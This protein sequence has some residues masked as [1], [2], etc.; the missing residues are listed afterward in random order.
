MKKILII[1][2]FECQK[3]VD[4]AKYI[5]SEFSSFFNVLISG[6]N[7]KK[8]DNLP[9][10]KKSD[11]IYVNYIISADIIFILDADTNFHKYKRNQRVIYF[12]TNTN[13]ALN[14]GR[15]TFEN[16]YKKIQ[17]I[18]DHLVFA[19]DNNTTYEEIDINFYQYLVHFKDSDITKV[20]DN[21]NISL[22][23]DKL[24]NELLVITNEPYLS[25]Y[26]K[27]NLQ[28]FI[29]KLVREYDCYNIILL[30]LDTST[31]ESLATLNNTYSTVI[32][33]NNKN[34][35][36]YLNTFDGV[37]IYDNENTLNEYQEILK[38]HNIQ[39]RSCKKINEELLKLYFNANDLNEFIDDLN[40]EDSLYTYN[41]VKALENN[42]TDE[43]KNKK[44]SVIIARYNTPLDLL[45]RAINSVFVSD[46][47]N[48]EVVLV[49]D[50]SK[51]NIEDKIYHDYVGK[52]IKYI[53][54]HNQGVGPAR[55]TGIKASSGDYVFFLDSDD[56]IIKTGLKLML[57]HSEIF[58]LDLVIG[59]RFICDENGDYI[60]H[61]FKNLAS[62]TY[63]VY[64]K[65][66]TNNVYEDNMPTNKLYKK[67]IF[68]ENNLLFESG[69]F[70]D[71]IFTAL[72][73]NYVDEYHYLNIPIYTW[74][75]YGEEST[76]SS[77][78]TFDNF[79]QRIKAYQKTWDIINDNNR[80]SLLLNNIKAFKLYLP[81]LPT[82]SKEEQ[83]MFFEKFQKYVMERISYYS[84][85]RVPFLINI[86][87]KYLMNNDFAGFLKFS[88]EYNKAYSYS[89]IVMDNYICY[90]H[91]HIYTAIIRTIDSKRPSRLY[92][93]KDYQKINDKFLNKIND[94]NIFEDVISFS[95]GNIVGE[96]K[97]ALINHPD[98]E[99]MIIEATLYQKFNYLFNNCN[100][101]DSVYVFN[102]SLP[103]YLTLEKK[104]NNIFRVEDAYNSFKRETEI[105]ND[106]G[107]W[108][109]ILSKYRGNMFPNTHG[110]SDK[111]KNI[112]VSEPIDNIDEK[113]TNKLLV[114]NINDISQKHEDELRKIFTYI[115]DTNEDFNENTILILTQP[116]GDNYCTIN[117]QIRLYQ[118]IAS[119]YRK[120]D[121]IIKPHP[122]DYVNY[123]KYGYKTL[124]RNVPIEVYNLSG[125]KIKKA[126][127]FGSSSI[128]L[129][130]FAQEKEILFKMDDFVTDDVNVAIKEL[131]GKE[132]FLD[133]NRVKNKLKR[134][135]KGK[136]NK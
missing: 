50:G 41:Y 101:N 134:T 42:Y 115:Y 72:L 114:S 45:Y 116:L 113:Y 7:I 96:L 92:V 62:N 66:V 58:N 123:S 39:D 59:K 44:I 133:V 70:E 2:N 71:A 53:Y 68:L 10:C 9:T 36:K 97:Q 103:D 8:L 48:I 52:D 18:N 132:K 125:K 108:G 130:D 90:T 102:D 74:Y 35:F 23:D 54:Q 33:I 91:F 47:K 57:I 88:D 49:D 32:N 31:N 98:N 15:R 5:F 67:S 110:L 26:S 38:N 29:N 117:E 69:Y 13:K 24:N 126:I 87:V 80:K 93:M 86:I 129:I 124:N 118:K 99:K 83:I 120:N 94:L 127:T 89:D 16:K 27:N 22:K 51:D 112:I 105:N 77:G 56:T 85:I 46:H 25:L 61:S 76:I 12:E 3:Q 78:R 107:V 20:I 60:G 95:Y 131:I 122:A 6:S 28:R 75:K 19:A 135:L 30:N 17:F 109:S 21:L 11:D 1:G 40:I 81:K 84:E 111:V 73:F 136:R 79:N 63:N 14:H 128:Y 65:N 34:I 100:V 43:I 37:I 121:V 55:N 106:F 82:Y 64:Y 104:F 119:K 4:Y